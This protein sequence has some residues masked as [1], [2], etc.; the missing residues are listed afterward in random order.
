[1]ASSNKYSTLTQ[2]PCNF[3]FSLPLVFLYYCQHTHTFLG[4][5]NDYSKANKKGKKE[6]RPG[7]FDRGNGPTGSCIQRDRVVE[8]AENWRF[9]FSFFFWVGVCVAERKKEVREGRRRGE[10]G[11][12]GSSVVGAGVIVGA[13]AEKES[14]LRV[15]CLPSGEKL[16]QHPLKWPALEKNLAPCCAIS[17]GKN[18]LSMITNWCV[19]IAFAQQT[20]EEYFNQRTGRDTKEHAKG[21]KAP[22]W[23]YRLKITVIRVK[24]TQHEAILKVLMI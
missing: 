18:N 4:Q 22:L 17:A 14:V 1:M 13:G 3:S 15:D 5:Q 11:G 16:F 24:I 20:L 2:F 21:F 23:S 8:C 19:T 6:G 12:G 9:F 7:V 10:R